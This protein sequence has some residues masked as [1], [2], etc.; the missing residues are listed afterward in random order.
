MVHH[1]F[2]VDRRAW[3]A[4]NHGG[5]M[6]RG[7]D[8]LSV[9][10]RQLIVLAASACAAC[11]ETAVSPQA[12]PAPPAP[13]IVQVENSDAAR[14]Q[15]G[16][17]GASIVYE[18]VAEGGVSR[19]SA[20]Y[21]S[22]PST[23]VGPVRSARLATIALL[24]QFRGVLVYS[25]ASRYIQSLLDSSGSPHYNETT[26]AGDL[27]R[28][29]GRAAP[30]N[31]YTDGAHLADLLTHASAPSIDYSFFSRRS[32]KAPGRSVAS[33]TVAISPAEA[34]VWTWDAARGGW[35]RSE[36]DTGPLLDAADGR[37][38]VSTTVIVQQVA[39]T[40]APQVVD[41]NGAHGVDHQLAGS[42]AAQVFVGGKEFALSNW[43]PCGS[44]SWPPAT[45]PCSEVTGLP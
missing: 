7:P 14:P 34:P 29:S 41:A 38:V 13:L 1:W 21:P 5:P 12:T 20:I 26:A 44:N 42:G 43:D 31:L 10:W 18:Y 45:R 3:V 30:H 24:H 37:P 23:K 6:S 40:E 32:A 25:G 28:S 2:D 16:L 11:G 9:P 35:T 15:S 36:P 17:Q 33:F 22:P 27:F 8:M 39:V 4:G 19:F